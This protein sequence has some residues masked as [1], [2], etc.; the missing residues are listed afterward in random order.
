MAFRDLVLLTRLVLGLIGSKRG[1]S[2]VSPL[3]SVGCQTS[4]QTAA[5]EEGFILE[6]PEMDFGLSEQKRA[7]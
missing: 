1:R 4:H 6:T 2:G 3:L 5:G 7:C